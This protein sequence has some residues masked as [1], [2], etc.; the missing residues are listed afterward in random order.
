[1]PVSGETD[2]QS[3][4]LFSARTFDA[5]LKNWLEHRR[6][7]IFHRTDDE[8]DAQDEA[9]N[10]NEGHVAGALGGF[11]T[12]DIV[13]R[14]EALMDKLEPLIAKLDSVADDVKLMTDEAVKLLRL[15]K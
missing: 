5:D 11:F 8:G 4:R 7:G 10:G 3:E 12:P 13:K 6:M 15:K 2:Q 9:A 1:M 14:A